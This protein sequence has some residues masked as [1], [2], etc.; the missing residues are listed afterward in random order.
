MAYPGSAKKALTAQVSFKGGV[1]T[2]TLTGALTL[3]ATSSNILKL[4]PG[5]ASRDVTLPAEESNDGL[6][7]WVKNAADAAEDIVLKNDAASTIVT[8]N[9]G[10]AALVA[11]NGSSWLVIYESANGTSDFGSTG[12]A[13]DVVAESTAAAGVTVDGLLIKDATI[14]P[15][16][17][18]TAFIDLTSVATGEADVVLKDNLASAFEVREAANTYLQVVTTN[19]QEAVKLGKVLKFPAPTVVDMADAAHALVYGTAG[20]G[21]TKL[22]SNIALVDPNSGQATEDLTLPAVATS[23][24]MMLVIINTGGEGIVVKDVAAATIITLD[25]AQHGIVVCDGTNWFGF[26]G[27]IT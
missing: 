1:D 18:G 19:D 22:T 16:A 25:T 13:A 5:G 11:C 26:M 9:M 20:A 17:G 23:V 15:A 27:G 3:D 4:D 12:I 10:E 14:K 21:E 2:L 8:L 24:G 6:F 7:F